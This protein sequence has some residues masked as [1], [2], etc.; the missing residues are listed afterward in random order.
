MSGPRKFEIPA[1]LTV[2][3]AARLAGVS[4]RTMY[5]RVE[6]GEIEVRR[7]DGASRVSTSYLASKLGI[8]ADELPS[9]LLTAGVFTSDGEVAAVRKQQ[10]DEMS[11]RIVDMKA[12]LER[13]REVVECLKEESARLRASLAAARVEIKSERAAKERA[14]AKLERLEQRVLESFTSLK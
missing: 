10:L 8:A 7:I 14:E 2:T 6:E 9:L 12:E 13:T 11:D 3:Q 5:R 4:R 1:W